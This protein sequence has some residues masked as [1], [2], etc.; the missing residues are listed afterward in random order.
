MAGVFIHQARP[1]LA[2]HHGIDHQRKRE[3]LGRLRH[4]L[5][6]FA[7]AERAGLGGLRR[8]VV[9]YSANLCGNQIRRKAV[10]SRDAQ[11]VL[12]GDQGCDGFSI[13]S[14]AVKSFEIGLESRAATRV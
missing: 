14:E 5:D 3:V 6:Y 4:G 10:D 9:D 2:D 11:C 7:R 12:H 8:D 1:V 13:D